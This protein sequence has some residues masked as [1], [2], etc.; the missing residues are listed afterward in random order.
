MTAPRRRW[1]GF[2]LRTLFVATAAIGAVAATAGVNVL[3]AVAM[4]AVVIV[5]AEDA[6]F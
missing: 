6:V 5:A 1:F 4:S 3:L 2:G